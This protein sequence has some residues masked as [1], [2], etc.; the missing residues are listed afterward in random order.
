[1]P[2]KVFQRGLT[3][4]GRGPDRN[5]RGGGG[6]ARSKHR[7]PCSL[8][9]WVAMMNVPLLLCDGLK[10]AQVTLNHGESPFL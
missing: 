6:E 7:H 8:C 10:E 2:L 1:M 9:I 5:R 3:N 4:V